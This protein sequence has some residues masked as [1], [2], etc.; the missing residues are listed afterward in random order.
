MS[1]HWTWEYFVTLESEQK[2]STTHR[3]KRV[4]CKLCMNPGIP[5]RT[6]DTMPAQLKSCPAIVENKQRKKEGQYGAAPPTLATIH[7]QIAHQGAKTPPVQ[8]CEKSSHACSE[9]GTTKRARSERIR[10]YLEGSMSKSSEKQVHRY[11]LQAL[12]AC[13]IPFGVVDHR[14]WQAFLQRIRPAYPRMSSYTFRT[15][16]LGEEHSTVWTNIHREIQ[17]VRQDTH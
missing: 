5:G 15:R 8:E 6:S 9:I 13:D 11:L 14:R 2:S 3:Y 7:C 1:T 16:I 12:I 10:N 17:I 4:K